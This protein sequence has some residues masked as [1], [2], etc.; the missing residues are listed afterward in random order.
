MLNM[1]SKLMS[2]SQPVAQPESAIGKGPTYYL[3]YLLYTQVGHQ[4]SLSPAESLQHRI[5]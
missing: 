4:T 1:P 2:L 5:R 3:T